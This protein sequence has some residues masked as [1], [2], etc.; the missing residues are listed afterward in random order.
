MLICCCFISCSCE[1]EGEEV[2]V[3]DVR[4]MLVGTWMLESETCEKEPF[5]KSNSEIEL[6]ANG[7][8]GFTKD[9][10][11]FLYYP[12]MYD[13]QTHILSFSTYTYGIAG[14]I[15]YIYM[16]EVTK[17]SE[18][19][20]YLKFIADD[21]GTELVYKKTSTE[22]ELYTTSGKFKRADFYGN[23]MKVRN[24][25]LDGVIVKDTVCYSFSEKECLIYI[26]HPFERTVSRK[27]PGSYWLYDPVQNALQMPV[28]T[29]DDIIPKVIGRDVRIVSE[30]TNNRMILKSFVYPGFE[31][32]SYSD[33]LYRVDKQFEHIVTR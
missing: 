18:D 17:I 27:A 1:D 14:E 4:K 16:Y 5:R 26:T 25:N 19:H 22:D 9:M 2:P 7:Y 32:Y 29:G 13:P 15:S 20:L 8:T 10:T 21:S 30:I 28:T 12:W 11:S 24:D 3:Q 6:C 31:E 33:T 23:W